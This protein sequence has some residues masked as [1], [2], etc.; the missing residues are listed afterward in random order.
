MKFQIVLL[1]FLIPIIAFGQSRRSKA[2]RPFTVLGLDQW[3]I[4]YSRKQQRVQLPGGEYLDIEMRNKKIWNLQH[5]AQDGSPLSP[6][7]FSNGN[8]TI[9][10][11]RGNLH[12]VAIFRDGILSDSSMFYT[13]YMR[14]VQGSKRVIYYKDGF[15]HGTAKFY[16]YMAPDFIS[17]LE[18]Y[19]MGELVKV[20]QFGKRV[21]KFG[22]IGVFGWV[23]LTLQ[24]V[25][26]G[27]CSRTIYK[28]GKLV[29]HTC[30]VRR[31]R[32]CGY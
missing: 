23:P 16:S 7:T 22:G 1:L 17:R 15:R 3:K 30:F 11:V 20:E 27:V 28:R 32:N 9:H 25:P 5:F 2:D 31:C 14:G 10:L 12:H 24:H 19:E 6:G 18:Y 13:T 26:T 21:L 29:S 8:G 4:S